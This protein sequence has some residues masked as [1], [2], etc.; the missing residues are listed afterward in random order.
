MKRLSVFASIALLSFA[1]AVKATTIGMDHSNPIGEQ[2]TTE[3]GYVYWDSFV[4]QNPDAGVTLTDETPDYSN[5]RNIT[6]AVLSGSLSGGGSVTGSG[7]RIYNG[8]GASSVAF[9]LTIEG[10]LTADIQTIS[11]QL[12]MSTPDVSTGLNRLTFFTVTLNGMTAS[13][14]VETNSNTGEVISGQTYGV[15]T[16]YWTGLNLAANSDF[17]FLLSSPSLGHVS[18]DG[19]RVDASTVPEPSTYAMMALGLG[20]VFFV[21]RRRKVCA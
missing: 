16:Y 3:V 2:E 7:D 8:S 9:D 13:A 11:L 10:T 20:M 6:D 5:G 15:V 14:V 21:V 4:D 18:L 12:K 17:T 1:G 19:V